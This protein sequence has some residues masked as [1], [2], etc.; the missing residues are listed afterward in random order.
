MLASQA[1]V[2]EVAKKLKNCA[3]T[4]IPDVVAQRSALVGLFDT[5]DG[6]SKIL[7][8][9][10]LTCTPSNKKDVIVA[11]FGQRV[12]ACNRTLTEKQEK[13]FIQAE[14]QL[15]AIWTKAIKSELQGVLR[16]SNTN[17]ASVDELSNL[18]KLM[19]EMML[20]RTTIAEDFD[21]L[22]RDPARMEWER[23]AR[24]VMKA[25]VNNSPDAKS[26]FLILLSDLPFEKS[27]L[28]DAL[29]P[30]LLSAA[31]ACDYKLV[32]RIAVKLVAAGVSECDTAKLR[33]AA[34][35]DTRVTQAVLLSGLPFD[36]G[37][38]HVQEVLKGMAPDPLKL[39]EHLLMYLP[40]MM[41]SVNFT[42]WQ[43]ALYGLPLGN[44]G[45]HLLWQTFRRQPDLSFVKCLAW[46]LLMLPLTSEELGQIL[47]EAMG[48]EMP[49]K[50][51][52][53]LSDLPFAV[54]SLVDVLTETLVSAA[55][56][57][58]HDVVASIVARLLQARVTTSD[59][60]P[61]L[62]AALQCDMRAR[63]S[64][65]LTEIPFDIG[66][67]VG[68]LTQPLILFAQRAASER[69]GKASEVVRAIGTKL[70]ASG[71][72]LDDADAIV[73]R[74]AGT[75]AQLEV[76]VSGL[77][78]RASTVRGLLPGMSS[79]L[80]SSEN[81]VLDWGLARQVEKMLISAGVTAVGTSVIL[82]RALHQECLDFV[83]NSTLPFEPK[84]LTWA[85][86]ELYLQKLALREGADTLSELEEDADTLSAIEN[87]CR[88]AGANQVACF[89]CMLL[90]AV[91]KPLPHKSLIRGLVKRLNSMGIT[92]K[93]ADYLLENARPHL[94]PSFR[95][96]DLPFSRAA[97]KK[98][99]R[100]P[101]ATRGG[102]NRRA[103][104]QLN[105]LGFEA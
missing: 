88:R 8:M 103:S 26:K 12:R 91:E 32:A 85:L 3:A 35:S 63:L 47:K 34:L 76:L 4:W 64:I 49:A 6:K 78:F 51:A 38:R 1:A 94:R 37:C 14:P 87:A 77:S 17:P 100:G 75:R 15:S 29:T 70:S 24:I 2:R 71:I 57:Q 59:T 21:G 73:R 5:Q 9:G 30:T 97:L 52:V 95:Q 99:V 50:L 65:L 25:Y 19:A 66:S 23:L 101:T 41:S 16:P 56:T 10:E 60:T 33:D 36:L 96:L 68:A 45:Q 93:E 67:L 46:R 43:L 62:E 20:K 83:L 11:K 80:V 54:P 102:R 81:W 55:L 74:L 39:Q 92:R 84:K 13:W 22:L 79:S 89:S 27:K 90:L 82:E 104:G 28:I 69:D 105:A 61:I 86:S 31:R 98:T 72:T 48:L 53:L 40:E 42:T 58:R 7:A 18:A 44:I